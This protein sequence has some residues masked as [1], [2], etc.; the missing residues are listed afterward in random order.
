[1][2]CPAVAGLAALVAS[3]NSNWSGMEIKQLI[4]D[5]VQVKDKYADIVSTSG[6]IDV[7]KTIKAAAA[8][9]CSGSCY[10]DYWK[11]DNYCDDGNNNCGCEWDG[12]DC[13]GT[14]NKYQAPYCTECECLDPSQASGH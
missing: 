5:N 1:M 11:G 3:M 9:D 12:G 14:E 6:L 4:M 13:C 7:E 10:R 8:K 2:A